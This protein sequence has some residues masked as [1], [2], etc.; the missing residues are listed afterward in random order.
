MITVILIMLLGIVVGVWLRTKP[1]LVL[2]NDRL[3]TY[4]IYLLLL[5]LGISIGSNKTIVS[6]LPILGVKAFL[7]TLGAVFG[8]V[9]LAFVTY[10]VFFKPKEKV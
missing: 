5:L 9:L 8:S 6:N 1:K 7:I 2:L 4:A 3:T 10:R